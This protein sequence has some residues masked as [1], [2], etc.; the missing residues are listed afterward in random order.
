MSGRVASAGLA[1]A[2]AALFLLAGC[3]T[4]PT[5][6]QKRTGG[7]GYY[8]YEIQPGVHFLSIRANGYTSRSTVMDYWYRRAAEICGGEDRFE[9]LG[10]DSAGDEVVVGTPSL[11]NTYTLPAVEGRI[12]CKEK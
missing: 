8:D 4:G 2:F 1:A 9:V 12:R 11:L 7:E 6:Y 10:M 3:A 5:P